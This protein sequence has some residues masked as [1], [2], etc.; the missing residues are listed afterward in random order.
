[1]IT[2]SV[3]CSHQRPE[4]PPIR[5]IDAGVG[6][7]EEILRK[8]VLCRHDVADIN[9]AFQVIDRLERRCELI[10]NRPQ[11]N[12]N[13][14]LKAM[15]EK[16]KSLFY[17]EHKSVQSL[18]SL[19]FLQDFCDES[20]K[21]KIKDCFNEFVA[22]VDRTSREFIYNIACHLP[23]CS[24]VTNFD[25][26]IKKL[27]PNLTVA[28]AKILHAKREIVLIHEKQADIDIAFNSVQISLDSLEALKASI[29]S[30]INQVR[31][32]YGEE[33]WD[34]RVSFL[35][36]DFLFGNAELRIYLSTAHEDCISAY[37]Y[38]LIE[39]ELSLVCSSIDRSQASAEMVAY[40]LDKLYS[41]TMK[42]PEKEKTFS[43][44]ELYLLDYWATLEDP[45]SKTEGIVKAASR[46]VVWMEEKTDRFRLLGDR[47]E[48]NAVQ[49]V[50]KSVLSS[51]LSRIHS[52]GSFLNIDR[53]DLNGEVSMIA[54]SFLQMDIETTA[55]E[56]AEEDA[57][58]VAKSL[59]RIES[60]TREEVAVKSRTILEARAAK[61]LRFASMIP[62]KDL[63]KLE[64]RASSMPVQALEAGARAIEMVKS[65]L[66]A[67]EDDK[68]VKEVKE[69][70]TRAK[71]KAREEAYAKGGIRDKIRIVSE[72]LSQGLFRFNTPLNN[73][74]C[75]RQTV[76]AWVDKELKFWENAVTSGNAKVCWA[77]NLP[78]ALEWGISVAVAY[79]ILKA[80]VMSHDK[81]IK[82]QEGRFSKILLEVLDN[83]KAIWFWANKNVEAWKRRKL[84]VKMLT[85]EEAINNSCFFN[86]SI[87]RN[88]DN[89][90]VVEISGVGHLP[91]LKN[92]I[93]DAGNSNNIYRALYAAAVF[94]A[95]KGKL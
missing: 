90:N 76:I 77:D 32:I 27:L 13:D 14:A 15:I 85:L 24:S 2:A 31:R 62:R 11:R 74:E 29:E 33:Q 22:G 67:R 49:T 70:E 26:D 10:V 3:L 45:S 60:K 56:N 95:Y 35:A 82:Y 61:M 43:N 41:A 94:K 19:Y 87:H 47:D 17:D 34:E 92:H 80:S 86:L 44:S 81:W 52:Y 71:K 36:D 51:Y 9:R 50:L 64:D 55:L 12:S 88:S 1:M 59:L 65:V 37:A 53:N 54:R 57:L 89:C 39:P 93:L 46:A 75:Q 6:I 23:N 63:E 83:K 84:L 72:D 40:A 79:L 16:V 25:D 8:N 7:V 18:M 28:A 69:A 78:H 5:S 58:A 21:L 68:R 91:K 73:D 4:L 38:S 30:R 42:I 20:L 48:A 66:I